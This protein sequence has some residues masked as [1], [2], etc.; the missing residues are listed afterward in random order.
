MKAT[1]NGK[2]KIDNRFDED[3]VFSVSCARHGIPMKLANI[4]GGE[5]YVARMMRC[6]ADITYIMFLVFSTLW[7]PSNQSLQTT[8]T[9]KQFSSCMTLLA[10]ITKKYW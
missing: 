4:Y 3:G 1:S 2:R 7:Q 8:H 6:L 5:G 9:Q 10:V